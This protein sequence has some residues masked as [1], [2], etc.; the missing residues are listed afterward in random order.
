MVRTVEDQDTL[1][2]NVA[3]GRDS[4]LSRLSGA[5]MRQCLSGA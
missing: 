4:A 1:D 2:V 3:D 5:N